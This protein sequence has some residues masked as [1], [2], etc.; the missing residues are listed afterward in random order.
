MGTAVTS[1]DSP[2]I[3]TA[4]V[5]VPSGLH[6]ILGDPSFGPLGADHPSILPT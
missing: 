5:D 6:G 1:P 3:P 2:E 4:P